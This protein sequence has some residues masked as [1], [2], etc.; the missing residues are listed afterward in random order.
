[1]CCFG[2]THHSCR[3]HRC[4]TSNEVEAIV[5]NGQFRSLIRARRRY[6]SSSFPQQESKTFPVAHSCLHLQYP[7]SDLSMSDNSPQPGQA[8][9]QQGQTSPN[10]SECVSGTTAQ[11]TTAGP[12]KETK[13]FGTIE[14]PVPHVM[15]SFRGLQIAYGRE[16][17]AKL[18][19]LGFTR[20]LF[21][22]L[23]WKATFDRTQRVLDLDY[24]RSAFAKTVVLLGSFYAV[25]GKDDV[26][27]VRLGHI[28]WAGMVGNLVSITV[29]FE[30]EP[31]KGSEWD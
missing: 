30:D 5:C 9:L 17:I 21:A 23:L 13:V 1:M 15:V 19:R 11:D 18:G 25:H 16:G 27:P 29:E 24:G 26:G 10:P 7:D 4:N 6:K 31:E 28:G 3:I 22:T 20:E 8:A 14:W 12:L 2:H